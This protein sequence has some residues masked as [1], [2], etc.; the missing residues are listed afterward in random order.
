MRVWTA[1]M[2]A[3]LSACAADPRRSDNPTAVSIVEAS[4]F[5]DTAA[6]FGQD[7]RIGAIDLLS[8][9][10]FQVPELSVAE[11]R[12]DAAG[13][14][15]MPLIG[16][17]RAAGRTPSEL[18]DE[19]RHQ[20]GLRY[21]QNPAVTVTVAEAASQKVTVDGAVNK[22]GVYTMRGRTTLLQAVAMAEGVDRA[23][24][25]E[26]VAVFRTGDQ[27]RMVAIFDL[28]AIRRGDATDPQ[29]MGDDVVVV[30]TSRLNAAIRDIIA[31]APALAVFRYF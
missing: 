5:P 19:I 26:S 9:T 21:L 7:Y 12:V 20:L 4:T 23:A 3:G 13:N 22:P 8:V 1:V 15:Q 14:I 18:A 10:V 17:V 2:V 24:D 28:G 31:T 16:S 6:G 29:L 27:G 11:A 25:L 30:D